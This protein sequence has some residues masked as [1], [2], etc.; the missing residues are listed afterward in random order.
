[1]IANPE[2]VGPKIQGAAAPLG[3]HRRSVLVL[4]SLA[5]L[6]VVVLLA[7]VGIGMVPIAPQQ[8]LV[9]FLRHS[10]ESLSGTAVELPWSATVQQDA[11]LLTIRVPR[12]ILGA[13]TGAGLAL[14]GAA[15]QGL[16]RNPLADPG[17]IGVS[18]GAALAAVVVIVLG[19]TWLPGVIAVLGI[20]TLPV[21]AFLGGLGTTWVVYSVSCVSGRTVVATMLLVGIAINALAQSGVSILSFIASD[22]QLRSIVFWSMGSLGGASWTKVWPVLLSTALTVTI[23]LG[24]LSRPLNVLLLGEAEA[25]YL[26]IHTDGIKRCIVAL[27]ALTVGAG[28]AATGPI[29]FVGLVVPHLLRLW[30]GPD[31]R[32]LLPGVLLLG[33]ILLLVADLIARTV[34]AP[35]EL[36]IGIVTAAMGAPFFLFLLLRQRGQWSL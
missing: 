23:M 5:V 10:L 31:H 4:W 14:S 27:V 2:R 29:G 32:Y 36:P 11:V 17:L 9:T 33:A 3:S 7:S 30:I 8:V 15:M 6:L 28:V 34:L 20:F 24:W 16:F 26:G 18:S 35:A 25:G 13:L 22:A 21:A 19:T 1:M 12:V